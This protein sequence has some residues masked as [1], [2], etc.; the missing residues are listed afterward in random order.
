M[1]GTLL[2]AAR[3]LVIVA[4][5][6]AGVSEA[7]VRLARVGLATVAGY[8]EGG[9]AA[10]AASAR[11]VA[12]VPQIT[13][14]ELAA[15]LQEGQDLLVL[16]VRRPAEHA[17]GHV[18]GARNVPLD[19]LERDASLDSMRPTA[20]ICAGGYRSSAGVSL[21]ARRGFRR[22][23][24]VVGGTTAWIQARHRVEPSLETTP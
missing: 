3:P 9:L 13:V 18:P 6:E 16:D 23:F 2:P 12:T 24:N 1:G 20:V 11:P 19:R 14:D 4:D 7:A 17:T 10:W 21:L 8:L 22:L 15:R 5:D